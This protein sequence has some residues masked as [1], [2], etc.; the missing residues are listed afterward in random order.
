TSNTLWT[1]SPT[2]HCRCATSHRFPALAVYVS[3]CELDTYDKQNAV[4]TVTYT[5]L[6]LSHITPLPRSGSTCLY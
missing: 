3:I 5:T 1:L 2:Q 4:D 6:S